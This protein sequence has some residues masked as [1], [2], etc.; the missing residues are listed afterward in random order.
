[1]R[2]GRERLK[3]LLSNSIAVFNTFFLPQ[4]KRN[5]PDRYRNPATPPLHRNQSR[6][7]LTSS[8]WL[9]KKCS[10]G[11]ENISLIRS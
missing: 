2:S 3:T 11:K 10:P 4:Q 7:Y 9:I 8:F 1:M 5:N 6:T